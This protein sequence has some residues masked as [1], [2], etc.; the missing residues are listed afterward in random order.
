MVQMWLKGFILNLI[1]LY[2]S[3]SS[4]KYFISQRGGQNNGTTSSWPKTWVI[5]SCWLAELYGKISYKCPTYILVGQPQLVILVFRSAR[6]HD[7][8]DM[9][10]LCTCSS[11][12][13]DLA[14][15]ES[16]SLS[17]IDISY[18]SADCQISFI[19]DRCSW[20]VFNFRWPILESA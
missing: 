7:F 8:L 17:L 2:S 9:I 15:L 3:R 4:G 20:L 16:S 11:G 14:S 19:D 10:F 12:T 1:V 18:W 6:Y 13:D 5:S